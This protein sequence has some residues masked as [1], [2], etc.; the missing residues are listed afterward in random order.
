MT[1]CPNEMNNK[2]LRT[3]GMKTIARRTMRN[4]T[5]GPETIRSPYMADNGLQDN[6]K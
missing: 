6:R 2:A 1:K 5:I 3:M 4:G